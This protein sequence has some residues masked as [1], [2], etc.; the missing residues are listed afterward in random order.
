MRLSSKYVCEPVCVF[1]ADVSAGSGG[2]GRGEVGSLQETQ[3]LSAHLLVP[4]SLSNS[5]GQ[6]FICCLFISL[7]WMSQFSLAATIFCCVYSLANL[8][9]LL[10]SEFVTYKLRLTDW[11][12]LKDQAQDRLPRLNMLFCHVCYLKCRLA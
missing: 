12:E 10:Y 6:Q 11:K 5:A 1:T 9:Y 2:W 8:F 4:G 7:V 3:F